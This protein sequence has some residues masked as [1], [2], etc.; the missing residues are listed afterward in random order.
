MA[1]PADLQLDGFTE[2]NRLMRKLP[3]R[4][5]RRVLKKAV[6]AGTKPIV[7]A[8]KAK[9][10]DDTGLLKLALG[11]KVKS[12]PRKSTAYGVIGARF[13]QGATKAGLKK[14]AAAGH[15]GPRDPGF[16]AHLVEYGTQAHGPKRAKVMS[17]GEGDIVYGT[18]VKGTRPRPF[19]R[20]AY[21][22]NKRTALRIIGDTS[23]EGIKK[24]VTK[25]R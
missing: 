1:R 22:S 16:Y 3:D 12:N 10:S 20:P 11:A 9:V 23:W 25:L 15:E 5:A 8:A 24:E 6:R 13:G 7:K 18:L 19:L 21:T 17:A 2:L 14:L 4:T